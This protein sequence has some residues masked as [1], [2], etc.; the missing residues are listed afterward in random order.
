MKNHEEVLSCCT[1][2]GNLLESIDFKVFQD[3]KIKTIIKK[4]LNELF[5]NRPN[6]QS[7]GDIVGKI[8]DLDHKIVTSG[9]MVYKYV[10]L[11]S[12]D[13]PPLPILIML[14][15]AC[16]NDAPLR[17]MADMLGLALVPKNQ[18]PEVVQ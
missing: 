17:A 11:A 8:T 5:H 6:G 1:Q 14:M 3:K 2:T 9:D 18:E 16:K 10:S 13:I 4:A 12:K 7:I 15:I